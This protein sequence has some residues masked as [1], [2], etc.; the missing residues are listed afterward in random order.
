MVGGEGLYRI[1]SVDWWIGER[2]DHF[3]VRV[4]RWVLAMGRWWWENGD[5]K[6]GGGEDPTSWC[7]IEV[8]WP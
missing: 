3:G 1:S 2:D 5:G 4:T 7:S 8:C 6:D